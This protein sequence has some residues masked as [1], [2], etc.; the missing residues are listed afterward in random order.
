MKLGLAFPH[1][2]LAFISVEF[3]LP[4]R[5]SYHFIRSFY[6]SSQSAFALVIVEKLAANLLLVLPSSLLQSVDLSFD[7]TGFQSYRSVHLPQLV[8]T[9]YYTDKCSMLWNDYACVLFAP[10]VLFKKKQSKLWENNC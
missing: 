1:A 7:Q 6:S 5:M 2:Y 10:V 4:T 9:Q 8:G 3:H